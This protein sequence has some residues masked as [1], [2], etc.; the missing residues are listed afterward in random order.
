VATGNRPGGIKKM[1]EKEHWQYI[2][3]HFLMKISILASF[4]PNIK[5]FISLTP[6]EKKGF[7]T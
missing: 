3:T 2:G 5:K 1:R 6:S 4:F 7:N